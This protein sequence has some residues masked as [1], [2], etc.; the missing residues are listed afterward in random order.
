M[1]CATSPIGAPTNINDST[2]AIGLTGVAYMTG[3]IGSASTTTLTD[4]FIYTQQIE[5]S[6]K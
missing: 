5:N 3:A 2:G 4:T 1:L 6:N